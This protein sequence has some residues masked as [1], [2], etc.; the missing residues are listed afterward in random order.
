VQ[1]EIF[2]ARAPYYFILGAL[3]KCMS[4]R[5]NTRLHALALPEFHETLHPDDDRWE[6]TGQR[7]LIFRVDHL[8]GSVR[9]RMWQESIHYWCDLDS[10]AGGSYF[11]NHCEHCGARVTDRAL[12]EEYPGAFCA[13]NFERPAGLHFTEVHRPLQAHAG[14]FAIQ[15]EFFP[16]IRGIR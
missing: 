4:C 2:N 7:A 9:G 12:H 14:G 8:S 6:C 13:P 1:A 15:P 16:R 5:E 3:S 11:M 10:G